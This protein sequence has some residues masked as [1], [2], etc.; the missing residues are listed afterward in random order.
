ML[1]MARTSPEIKIK[2]YK[3]G[4]GIRLNFVP[5]SLVSDEEQPYPT[6]PTKWA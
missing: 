3:Q 4:L 5:V 1:P 6:V 2:M